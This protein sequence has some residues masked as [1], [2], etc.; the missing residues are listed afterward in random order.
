M[1]NSNFSKERAGGSAGGGLYLFVLSKA[2]RPSFFA[3]LLVQMNSDGA[4]TVCTL[5]KFVRNFAE[6]RK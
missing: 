6:W 1:K 2:Q 3:S 5:L 4:W